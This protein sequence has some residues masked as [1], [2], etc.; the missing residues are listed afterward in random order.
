MT[1]AWL[2]LGF[3]AVWGSVLRHLW[4]RDIAARRTAETRADKAEQK[5]R[6]ADERAAVAEDTARQ[7]MAHADDLAARIERHAH[8][9]PWA[10]AD[11]EQARLS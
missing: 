4:S 2:A 6:E 11:P 7:W 9:C 3:L 1:A 5:T 10:A 8:R